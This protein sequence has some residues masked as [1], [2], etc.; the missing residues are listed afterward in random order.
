MKKKNKL[1]GIVKQ[2]L[3]SYFLFYLFLCGDQGYGKR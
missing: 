2:K 3:A 1:L